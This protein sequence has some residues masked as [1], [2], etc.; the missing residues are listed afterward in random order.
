MGSLFEGGKPQLSR[1]IL[2]VELCDDFGVDLLALTH[3]DLLLWDVEQHQE[4]DALIG[5]AQK[6]LKT[7][8]HLILGQE[9]KDEQN[10]S[11]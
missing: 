1:S 5:D 7:L 11:I 3:G 6:L 9:N 10:V 4:G 2:V 8:H